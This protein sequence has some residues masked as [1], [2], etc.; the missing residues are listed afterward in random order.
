MTWT[1][2]FSLSLS[3]QE[4]FRFRTWPQRVGTG[5]LWFSVLTISGFDPRHAEQPTGKGSFDRQAAKPA[6]T[7]MVQNEQASSIRF[8]I[9]LC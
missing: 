5:C 8:D 2:V 6:A 9:T 1:S 7:Q 4:H 3:F